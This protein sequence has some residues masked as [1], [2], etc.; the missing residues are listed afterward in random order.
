MKWGK[1]AHRMK[2]AEEAQGIKWASPVGML[3]SKA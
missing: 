3:A 1:D 2:W